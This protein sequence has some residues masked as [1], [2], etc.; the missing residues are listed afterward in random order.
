V[1]ALSQVPIITVVVEQPA[2]M[3]ETFAV[4]DTITETAGLVTS[5]TVRGHRATATTRARG[6]L[7]LRRLRHQLTNKPHF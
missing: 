7:S 4:I 1:V 3:R 2:R 5:E 6:G